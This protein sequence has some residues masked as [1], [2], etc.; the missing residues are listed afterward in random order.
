MIWMTLAKTLIGAVSKNWQEKREAE[1]TQYIAELKAGLHDPNKLRALK[2]AT[3]LQFSAP[4]Y[5]GFY[6]PSLL[7]T[8]MASLTKVPQ[9]YVEAYLMIV[10]GVWAGAVGKDIVEGL[11]KSYRRKPK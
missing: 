8:L 11:M 7:D 9:W 2:W 1:H 3:F 5:L 6:D 4:I 10:G